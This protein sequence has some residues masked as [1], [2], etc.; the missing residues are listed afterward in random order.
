METVLGD[1]LPWIDTLQRGLRT[2]LAMSV[3]RGYAGAPNHVPKEDL[4][5]LLM[6]NMGDLRHMHKMMAFDVGSGADIM[7]TQSSIFNSGDMDS[8]LLTS[9]D[10]N[11]G[12]PTL[13]SISPAGIASAPAGTIAFALDGMGQDAP[14]GRLQQ[15]I[16]MATNTPQA[17]QQ[18]MAMA[19]LYLAQQQQQ[20][21]QVQQQVQMQVQGMPLMAPDN[22]LLTGGAPGAIGSAAGAS[23]LP[24]GLQPRVEPASASLY[25][26]NLPPDATELLLY[27]IFAPCGPILSCRV[28]TDPATGACRGVGFVNYADGVSARRALTQLQ[29]IRITEGRPLSIT[30]QA[31]R[32]IRAAAAA[33]QAVMGGP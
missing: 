12:W 21:Q 7:S 28:H 9:S 13:T 22:T 24:I 10:N 19:S 23:T 31:P 16:H 14:R 4:N 2:K 6:E 27:R 20:Q 3:N 1:E 29:G 25:V 18:A 5:S 8:A 33:A 30:L 11:Q 26:K 15:T 17:R 32:A